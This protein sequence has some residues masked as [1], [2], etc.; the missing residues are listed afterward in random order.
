MGPAAPLSPH[1]V[2][3]AAVGLTANCHRLAASLDTTKTGGSWPFFFFFFW[4]FRTPLPQT[5]PTSV[6]KPSAGRRSARVWLARAYIPPV[7][8]FQAA[9]QWNAGR[10]WA[11][12]EHTKEGAKG[13]PPPSPPPH[14]DALSHARHLPATPPCRT[15]PPLVCAGDALVPPPGTR[16]ALLPR[17]AQLCRHRQGRS[18]CRPLVDAWATGRAPVCCPWGAKARDPLH[19]GAYSPRALET[20]GSPSAFGRLTHPTQGAGSC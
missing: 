14:E 13:S 10:R 11:A 3:L 18:L 6:R 17:G 5:I 1:G 8:S 20:G 15:V 7:C 4:L 12:G 16:P 19:W 9:N 2:F